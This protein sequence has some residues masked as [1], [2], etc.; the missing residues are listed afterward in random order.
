M[1]DQTSMFNLT[2][3]IEPLVRVASDCDR[4][5]RRMLSKSDSGQLQGKY[6]RFNVQQGAQGISLW[7]Y[8]KLPELDAHTN[9]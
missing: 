4:V 1:P 2:G 6:F 5:H 7:M 8:E 3:Q 9:A